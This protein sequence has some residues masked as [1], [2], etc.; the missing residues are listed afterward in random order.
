MS[1][2]AKRIF[3]ADLF[4]DLEIIEKIETL[5]NKIKIHKISFPYTIC[6]N[7]ECDLLN[8]YND[9][10][11]KDHSLI[12]LAFAPAFLFEL[13]LSGIHWGGLFKA[14]DPQKRD[15]SIVKKIMENEIPRYHY[16]RFDGTDMPEMIIDFKHF[17]TINKEEV[18]GQ[19]S[20]RVC[21]FDDLFREKI[22]QR[23]SNYISRIG[24]PEPNLITQAPKSR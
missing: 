20:K 10:A 3:Q 6:L 2:Q 19:I 4:Q 14:G 15:S 12:H 23:F 13:Y 8:D 22:S 24:L 21:S 11:N 18:Y 1:G 7:Q 17:F 5:K 16:L 9:I